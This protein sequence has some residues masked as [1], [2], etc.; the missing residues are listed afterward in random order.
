[1][2]HA[3]TLGHAADGHG[4]SIDLKSAGTLLFVGI[5]RHDGLR[6]CCAVSQVLSQPFSQR[7]DTRADAVDRELES[8]DTG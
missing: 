3:G 7:R 2:D 5:G 4:L 6:R 1:M 8:Y